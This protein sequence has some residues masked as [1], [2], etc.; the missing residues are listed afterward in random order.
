MGSMTPI[1][2]KSALSEMGSM[3]LAVRE[4]FMDKIASLEQALAKSARLDGAR[5]APC[6]RT[7]RHRAS[8][9]RTASRRARGRPCSHKTGHKS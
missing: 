5:S 3:P 1:S 6:I 9:P 8:R 4:A 2:D 7:H